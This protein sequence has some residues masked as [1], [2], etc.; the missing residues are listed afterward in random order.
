MSLLSL[1]DDDASACMLVCLLVCLSVC[2]FSFSFVCQRN[3][4]A[5]YG[6]RIREN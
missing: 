5:N 4:E 6:S 3:Y 1:D 2:L